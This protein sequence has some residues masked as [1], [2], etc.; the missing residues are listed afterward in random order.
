MSCTSYTHIVLCS[1]KKNHIMI[2]NLSDNDIIFRY[3]VWT[4]P[5]C[6][7]CLWSPYTLIQYIILIKSYLILLHLSFKRF[8]DCNR[9]QYLVLVID[10]SFSL[11]KVN[12]VFQ[13]CSIFNIFLRLW[14]WFVIMFLSIIRLLIMFFNHFLWQF[15]WHPFPESHWKW[16]YCKLHITL[17]MSF[18]RW[19]IIMSKGNNCRWHFFPEPVWFCYSYKLTIFLDFY[20][21]SSLQSSFF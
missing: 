19:I 1:T 12:K 16:L 6:L 13:K 20:H 10:C 2:R 9:N 17:R 7:G 3:S 8:N 4:S 5:L 21:Y 11:W 18:T 15:H 14:I